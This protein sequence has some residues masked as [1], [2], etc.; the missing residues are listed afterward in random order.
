MTLQM[1]IVSLEK[2][3]ERYKT[4]L[5]A[6]AIETPSETSSVQD[7][8]QRISVLEKVGVPAMTMLTGSKTKYLMTNFPPSSVHSTKLINKVRRRSS[9]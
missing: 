5:E 1:R 6:E 9:I 3:V 4:Q 2:E 8:L 7:L